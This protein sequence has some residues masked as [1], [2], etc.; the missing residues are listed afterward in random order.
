MKHSLHGLFHQ[1]EELMKVINSIDPLTYRLESG[2]LRL[3]SAFRHVSGMDRCPNADAA[4]AI[5]TL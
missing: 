3:C 4:I 1:E 2:D 5:W